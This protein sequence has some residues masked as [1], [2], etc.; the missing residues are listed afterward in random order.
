MTTMTDF[1]KTADEA[2]Y[3]AKA[4]GKSCVRQSVSA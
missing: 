1:I 3:A 4:A 2:L